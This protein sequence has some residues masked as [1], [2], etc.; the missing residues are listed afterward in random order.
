[1]KGF[2]PTWCKWIQSLIQGGKVRIQVNDQ[3]WF[4]FQI[5]KGLRQGDPLS[6]ILFNI[7]MDMLAIILQRVKEDGQVGGVVTH[8]IDGG[9]SILD[10][11]IFLDHDI[12]QANNLKLILSLFEQLSGLKINFHKSENLCFGQAKEIEQYYSTLFHYLGL[13]MHYKKLTNKGW[14]FLEERIEKKLS[15]WKSKMLS[16]EKGGRLVLLNSV[17]S[18]LPMF[19]LSF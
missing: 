6:P 11:I 3:L 12:E 14:S 15:S 2:R 16:W 4:Y 1:M 13:L 18:S 8:L 7:V 10:T 9:L 5:K 17:L 19:M